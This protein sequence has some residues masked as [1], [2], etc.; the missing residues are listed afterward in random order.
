[1]LRVFSAAVVLFAGGLAGGGVRG[2]GERAV[3]GSLLGLGRFLRRCEKSFVSV[4]R[5]LKRPDMAAMVPTMGPSAP[6]WVSVGVNMH[7]KRH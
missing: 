7:I 2:G 6:S 4:A 3:S 5:P 1:M